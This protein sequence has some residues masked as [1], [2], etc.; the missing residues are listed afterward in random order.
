MYPLWFDMFR[1]VLDVM[2]VHSVGELRTAH[3]NLMSLVMRLLD[4]VMSRIRSC[5]VMNAQ[6]ER[7]VGRKTMMSWRARLPNW[8]VYAAWTMDAVQKTR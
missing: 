2:Q 4:N 6:R 7:R 8:R 1:G 5:P 3:V